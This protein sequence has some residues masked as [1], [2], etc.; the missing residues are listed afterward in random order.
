[1][2]DAFAGQM[3]EEIGQAASLYDRLDAAQLGQSASDQVAEGSGSLVT[4]QP[5]HTG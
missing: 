1:M 4:D 2:T 3:A 5:G